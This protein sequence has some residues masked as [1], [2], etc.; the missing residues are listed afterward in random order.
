MANVSLKFKGL[1]AV[2]GEKIITN[3][4]RKKLAERVIKDVKQSISI[5]KSPVKG[6]GR[7]VA[8]K[9]D[10]AT[11]SLR[12]NLKTASIQRGG[13]KALRG[14]LRREIKR[15]ASK[16]NLYPNSVK[17]EFPNK[18]RR[19]VNLELSGALIKAIRWKAIKCG[20]K[21][22][23]ISA[24]KK[25]KDIFIAHNEGANTAKKVPRR[26]ILPT[27]AGEKFTAVIQKRIR[28]LFLARIRQVLKQVNK[29]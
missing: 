14:E 29:K 21:I 3:K 17:G 19:P 15:T 22:G 25:L 6:Q 23:L 7:F 12:K 1:D 28:S 24:N 27:G 4:F 10:R 5:G 16:K 18:Q 2:V 20:V 26:A 13:K 11:S 8:Y 9:A